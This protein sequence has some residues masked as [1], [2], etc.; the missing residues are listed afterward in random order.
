[1]LSSVGSALCQSVEE[2]EKKHLDSVATAEGK[3]YE[4]VAAAEFSSDLSFMKST[5]TILHRAGRID[6][7]MI[8][9]NAMNSRG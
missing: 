9:V 4:S 3:A 2:F 8:Q 6:A 7:I 5:I 1:M